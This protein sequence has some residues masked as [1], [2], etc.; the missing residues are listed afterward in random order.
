MRLSEDGYDYG[1]P[2]YDESHAA[3]E[4]A[5]GLNF[6][7]DRIGADLG[8][9][10]GADRRSL[11]EPPIAWGHHS[12]SPVLAHKHFNDWY[13]EARDSNAPYSMRRG[14]T[15][16]SFTEDLTPYLYSVNDTAILQSISGNLAG[17]GPYYTDGSGSH[18]LRPTG[19]ASS[20]EVNTANFGLK[21]VTRPTS[22]PVST[23]PLALPGGNTGISD[24]ANVYAANF[25]GGGYSYSSQALSGAGIAPGTQVSADGVTYTMPDVPA[26]HTDNLESNGQT[27]GVPSAE[28]GATN[29]GFL[30]AA[31]SGPSAGTV[32]VNYADGTSET[33]PLGM[34]DWSL[35]DGTVQ[36]SYGNTVVAEMP[37]KN[38]Q[39]KGGRHTRPTY[40]FSAT[41]PVNPNKEVASV[42]LPR[43][44]FTPGGHIHIFDV[45]ASNTGSL[46]AEYFE[47][48]VVQE[49]RTVDTESLYIS[50][51]RSISALTSLDAA[52]L[53][54]ADSIGYHAGLPYLYPGTDGGREVRQKVLSASTSEGGAIYLGEK[55]ARIA[56]QGTISA[57]GITL[58]SNGE[59][60]V[61]NPDYPA[62]ADPMRYFS[63]PASIGLTL[64]QATHKDTQWPGAFAQT[65]LFGVRDESPTDGA[66]GER[67]LFALRYGDGGD[68]EAPRPGEAVRTP[69]AVSDEFFYAHLPGG[70]S[71]GG[72]FSTGPA[73]VFAD[74]ATRETVVRSLGEAVTV[75]LADL[76]GLRLTLQPGTT[77]LVQPGEQRKDYVLTSAGSRSD[78]EVGV[79]R[80]ATARAFALEETEGGQERRRPVAVARGSLNFAADEDQRY[81]VSFSPKG[82]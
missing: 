62:G 53:V 47:A 19:E 18:W 46:L 34:S 65:N 58:G 43:R 17:I 22:K 61:E 67:H 57:G 68:L 56:S 51:G 50:D 63:S 11:E 24:D 12:W 72:V 82:V 6:F 52:P 37:Y 42:T 31:H 21:F 44:P 60:V 29:L 4:G 1:G 2:R 8:R 81:L 30:G 78:L 23:R 40:V 38:S 33:H 28:P 32:R 13:A 75:E 41:V 64:D 45:A 74:R 55:G 25:D 20:A 59:L 69:T 71:E 54:P 5:A 16:V 15:S 35:S 80:G 10:L 3:Y 7:D 48:T 73:V 49:D 77:L 14:Q 66:R 26:G 36:P 79:P 27:V 76:D 70:V 39:K 9:Y